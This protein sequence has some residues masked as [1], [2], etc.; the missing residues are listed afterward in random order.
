MYKEEVTKH[1]KNNYDIFHIGDTVLIETSRSKH[2]KHCRM[3]IVPGKILKTRSGHHY[4]VEW[5]AANGSQQKKWTSVTELSKLRSREKKSATEN[6]SGYRKNT[7]FHSHIQMPS[8][9]ELMSLCYQIPMET[10]VASFLQ[11]PTSCEGWG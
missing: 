4:F 7:T 2:K 6:K 1:H 5:K 11:Q 8:S 10:V 9:V 3:H